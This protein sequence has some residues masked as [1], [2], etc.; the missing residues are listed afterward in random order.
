MHTIDDLWNGNIAPC[1]HCG[2]HDR[3]ANRLLVLMEQ[4][5]Q[6]ASR[7]LTDIQAEA[8]RQYT[9]R[10]EE[11]LLRMVELAFREG[12]CLGSQLAMESL[13]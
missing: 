1:E 11:Y 5:R 12:F 6:A 9:D 2:S 10:S 3:E 13:T 8:L 7:G 4:H